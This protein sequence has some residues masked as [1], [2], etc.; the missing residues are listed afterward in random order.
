MRKALPGTS[1]ARAAVTRMSEF[2]FTQAVA[3]LWRN[4]ASFVRE[5]QAYMTR[6]R[7]ALSA[8]PLYDDGVHRVY[9]K[10][11]QRLAH[12]TFSIPEER[13]PKLLCRR[14]YR[15]G[16]TWYGWRHDAERERAHGLPV[17]T[18]CQ[19]VYVEAAG[20]GET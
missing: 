17:C 15:S 18:R 10:A 11:S 19:H 2:S 14:A 12:L 16:T 1:R 6:N 13:A 8:A 20:R 5:W 7:R 9:R 4:D 3:S